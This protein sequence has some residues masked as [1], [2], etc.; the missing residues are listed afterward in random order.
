MVLSIGNVKAPLCIVFILW[1]TALSRILTVKN[2]RKWRCHL[3]GVAFV[4]RMR[5]LLIIFSFIVSISLTYVL[6][7][8]GKAKHREAEKKRKNTG[9]VKD[10]IVTDYC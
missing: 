8:K 9:K 6:E 10:Y 4:R 3:T 1:A 5:K 2:L 7:N